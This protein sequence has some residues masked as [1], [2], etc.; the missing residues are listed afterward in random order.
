MMPNPVATQCNL[1]KISR[2]PRDSVHNGH[3]RVSL[4]GHGPRAA[5]RS[6]QRAVRTRW[7]GVGRALRRHGC[8][9]ELLAPILG[10]SLSFCHSVDTSTLAHHGSNPLVRAGRQAPQGKLCAQEVSIVP[11][12]VRNPSSEQ[13][14]SRT[15]LGSRS[16]T[17]QCVPHVPIRCLQRQQPMSIVS[18]HLLL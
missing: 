18:K 15:G 3:R 12:T 10:P 6:S 14:D 13:G 11:I 5:R 4:C 16:G 7:S 2:T 1:F 8:G 17:P 9:H